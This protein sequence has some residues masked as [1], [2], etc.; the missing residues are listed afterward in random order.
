ML[1]VVLDI[2]I[3]LDIDPKSCS[4]VLTRLAPKIEKQLELIRKVELITALK[5]SFYLPGFI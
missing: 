5:V 3:F 4:L 2:Y 1:L